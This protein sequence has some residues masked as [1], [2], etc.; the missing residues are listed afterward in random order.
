MAATTFLGSAWTTTAG[1]KTVTGTPAVGDLI[2]VI[3]GATGVATSAVTDNAGGTYTQVG[4]TRTG[5]STTGNL[6]MWIRDS[7]ITAASSTIF[8]ATQASSTGGGLVVLRVS[9]MLRTGANAARQTSGQSA[10]TAATT[11]APVFPGVALT[12]NPVIG[13]V[14]NGATA[15]S[16]TAPASFT[17]DMDLG[18]STPS[19]GLETVHRDSGHTSATVTW[20]STSATAFA[21]YILELDTTALPG[22]SITAFQTADWTATT[23]TKTITVTGAVNGDKIIVFYGGD[24]GTG[25]GTVTAA[26]ASTTGGS[27]GTWT[28]PEEGFA[29]SSQTWAS[30]STADV[31]AN[32]TVTVTLSRTQAAAD[33]WG[34]FA[35]LCH[36]HGGIGVH[37]R[38]APSSTKT[39]SLTVSQDSAVGIL[40]IDWDH[41]TVAAFSPGGATD[42]LR[43]AALLNV[44]WYAGYWLAQAAGTRSYGVPASGTTNLHIIAIEIKAASGLSAALS[45]ALETDSA[46]ALAGKSKKSLSPV[47]AETD[48]AQAFAAITKK[49]LS[50]TA[51]ETDTAIPLAGKSKKSLSPV[52]A[53]TDTAQALG[54]ISRTTVPVANEADSAQALTRVHARTLAVANEADSSRTITRLSGFPVATEVDTAQPAGARS[55]RVLPIANE[56]DVARTITGAHGRILAVATTTD[57]AQAIA[58]ISTRAV[59]VANEA[60]TAQTLGRKSTLVVP[61]ATEVDTARAFAARKTKALSIATEGDSARII[62]RSKVRVLGT[63]LEVDTAL[64]LS[65]KKV[66]LLVPAVETDQARPIAS[67]PLVFI[68]ISLTVGATRKRELVTVLETRQGVDVGDTRKSLVVG[69]TRNREHFSI[70]ESRERPML[71]TGETRQGMQV[72]ET[73]Q[74]IDVG[75]TRSDR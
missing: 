51:V 19:A 15:A 72:G 8:T 64:V 48:T 63:A 46:I 37:A 1:N 55:T 22:P 32:G 70:H 65:R 6:Q 53:E 17:E 14:A 18:Y 29:A 2:V 24:N 56:A 36:N 47:A 16:M 39:V 49:L 54:R 52:A 38:S 28:E 7:F 73:R 62:S 30:S 43:S 42:V 27:T 33:I 68:D 13:A 45:T 41:A 40:G 35:I 74:G 26:T 9:G 11:P 67:G 12:G 66:V 69:G 44:T 31:T 21:S 5:F 57:T 60:D 25:G 4:T 61:T 20:G 23:A 58:R 3:T 10:G 34:G 75:D 50:P 59:S 71:A